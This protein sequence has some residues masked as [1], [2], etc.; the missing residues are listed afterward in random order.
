MVIY[1]VHINQGPHCFFVVHI[2]YTKCNIR[3]TKITYYLH[4]EEVYKFSIW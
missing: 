2:D 1:V 4:R 3:L